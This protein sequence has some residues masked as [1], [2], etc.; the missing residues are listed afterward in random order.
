MYSYHE[1]V[2]KKMVSVEQES[3]I[4]GILEILIDSLTIEDGGK[5]KYYPMFKDKAESWEVKVLSDSLVYLNDEESKVI[6]IVFPSFPLHSPRPI[7]H[8]GLKI[9]INSVEEKL[10]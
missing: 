7:T 6:F 9:I 3:W 10:I 1:D 8:P 5:I 4:L 2:S